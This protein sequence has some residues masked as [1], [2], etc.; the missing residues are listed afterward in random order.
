MQQA[1]AEGAP[2][3]QGEMVHQEQQ[4]RVGVGDPPPLQHIRAL[5]ATEGG[6]PPSTEEGV[7]MKGFTPERAHL[8]L[9]EVYVDFPHHKDGTSLSGRLQYNAI[10][11]SHLRRLSA[12]P[13][14]WYSPP[15]DN[16]ERRF[17]AILAAEWRGLLERK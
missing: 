11:K 1:S 9:R 7:D 8:T 10:W 3:T 6:A 15:Q 17:T 2:D 16:V 13:D 4:G 14:C 5:S 12:Q